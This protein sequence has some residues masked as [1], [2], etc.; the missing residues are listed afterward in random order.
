MIE[1]L[2]DSERDG[3]LAAEYWVRL[4]AKDQKNNASELRRL[5][6]PSV[7]AGSEMSK[8]NYAVSEEDYENYY[9]RYQGNQ[10]A[11][12]DAAMADLAAGPHWAWWAICKRH[13]LG[14]GAVWRY[15][16]LAPGGAIPPGLYT[17]SL[18]ELLPL[19]KGKGLIF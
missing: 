18:L 5:M 3:L 11:M 14:H 15:E 17:N 9:D 4:W 10:I 6:H 2:T 19:L 12:V 13:G 1:E 16:R 8:T 7:A